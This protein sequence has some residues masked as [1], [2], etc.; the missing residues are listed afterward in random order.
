MDLFDLSLD[1]SK[2]FTIAVRSELSLPARIKARMEALNGK[3]QRRTTF[4]PTAEKRLKN[5]AEEEVSYVD[6]TCTTE[7]VQLRSVSGDV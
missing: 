6:V 3:P 5:E 4:R 7:I 2:S 1:R